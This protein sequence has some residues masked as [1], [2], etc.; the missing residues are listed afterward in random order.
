[1]AALRSRCCSPVVLMFLLLTE[2]VWIFS[3]HYWKVSSVTELFW[4]HT[5]IRAASLACLTTL[6]LQTALLVFIKQL[7]ISRLFVILS[8]LILLILVVAVRSFFRLTSASPNW[9]RKCEKILVVGTDQ[10]ARRCVKLL[11]RIP[12]FDCD[13]RAYL[14][15][16]GQ[17]VLVQGAPVVSTAELLGLEAQAL[18]NRS[19]DTCKTYLQVSS[20]I[21]NL[22]NLG[23]ACA[24]HSG[25]GSP[26][27][28]AGKVFQVGRLQMM[29]LAI[30]P[31]ESF[32]YTVLKRTF[33]V[34]FAL[35]GLVVL[36][37]LMFAIAVAGQAEFPRTSPVSPRA[38]RTTRQ[39]VHLAEVPH[40]AVQ[41][42]NG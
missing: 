8:N 6:F 36:S 11:R 4:E 25:Y 2:A 40:H 35:F 32:T 10:Y 38:R 37:P 17:P 33:D 3:A 24:R 21:D 13:V 41:P 18:T 19:S 39:A 29:N 42:E 15:L 26:I 30:S 7:I 23:Q 34:V 12:F 20:V 28:G 14:Q 5:G 1:M 31:V 16:P 9:P 27:V 22:Q